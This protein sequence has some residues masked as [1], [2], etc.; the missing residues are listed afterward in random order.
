MGQIL[1]DFRQALIDAKAI[2]SLFDTFVR[3]LQKEHGLALAKE[4]VMLDASFCEVPRQRNSRQENAQ[5]KAGEVPKWVVE[6]SFAWAARFRRLARDY[7][8]LAS[9]LEG[10]H[11]LAFATLML[12]SFFRQSA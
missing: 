5:I 2:E 10:F 8:R 3:H 4:G 12:N 7:E 1:S 9:S 11:W 6:R